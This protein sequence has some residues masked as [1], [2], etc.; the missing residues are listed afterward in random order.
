MSEGTGLAIAIPF[1]WINFEA[2]LAQFLPDRHAPSRFSTA[3]HDRL[4]SIEAA[5]FS[6]RD[7]EQYRRF[8]SPRATSRFDNEN[9]MKT[10]DLSTPFQRFNALALRACQV[11][12]FALK[13]PHVQA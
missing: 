8:F 13:C 9:L 10:N 3:Q 12:A 1:N 5:E 7:C 4:S 6:L 11:P 2:K